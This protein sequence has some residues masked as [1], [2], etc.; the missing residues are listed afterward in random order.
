MLKCV[1]RG[2]KLGHAWNILSLQCCAFGRYNVHH[3][4]KKLR[5][6]NMKH[7]GL[8]WTAF[9]AAFMIGF[10]KIK[11]ARVVA[12]LWEWN[13]YPH[14]PTIDR[15]LPPRIFKFGSIFWSHFANPTLF[16][17]PFTVELYQY[18]KNS[19][20]LISNLFEQSNLQ[21]DLQSLFQYNP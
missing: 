8:N 13:W 16:Q 20:N 6:R 17:H 21:S 3:N 19:L 10:V 18:K 5:P 4:I 12:L 2:Y 14:W 9:F 1:E 11:T 7:K 15:R